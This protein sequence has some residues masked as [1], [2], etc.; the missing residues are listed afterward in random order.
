M[1]AMTIPLDDGCTGNASNSARCLTAQIHN[2]PRKADS[3]LILLKYWTLYAEEML[4]AAAGQVNDAWQRE[5][6]PGR[7]HRGALAQRPVIGVDASR[8]PEVVRA[9][10][11]GNHHAGTGRPPS[12]FAH[13][14]H[15]E[16]PPYL[17]GEQRAEVCEL[18]ARD[19]LP[20]RAVVERA[21]GQRRP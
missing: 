4:A 7:Q 19:V 17:L 1:P 2:G 11:L 10:P 16:R 3:W 8:E 14:R 21:R 15:P 13:A 5:Q 20:K 18:A 6:L 9:Q 12:G